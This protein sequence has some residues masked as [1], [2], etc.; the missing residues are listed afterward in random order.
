MITQFRGEY[1]WLSNFT[2]C[3]IEYGDLTFSSVELFYIAMKTKNEVTRKKLS[4]AESS[5][6]GKWKK[7]SKKWNIRRDWEDIKLDVMEY[8]L[9]QK[10]NQEPFKSKL[11]ATGNQN[12][13]EGNFW[14]DVFW[15]VDLKQNPNIGENHLGRLIM[16]IRGESE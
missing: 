4:L 11:I 5:E 16:K 12:I 13:Q 10:F 14:N 1:N 3:T 15:G 6:A 9:R 2:S 7:E 8:G